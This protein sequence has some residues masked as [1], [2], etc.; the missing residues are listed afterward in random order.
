MD[1]R[2]QKTRK[3]IFQAF[4]K[5]LERKNY[6]NITVQEIIDEADIGRSTF[7]AHF[8]TKDD[9]VREICEEIFSHVFSEELI[10][11]TT[12][13]FTGKREIDQR[14]THML[15]HLFLSKNYIRGLLACENGEIFMRYFKEYLAKV[16]EK[17][18]T[19]AESEIPKDYMLNHLVCDFA[20]T[21][22]WWMCHEKY[23]PEEISRFF[24]HTTPF[25]R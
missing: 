18:L 4:V 24:M 11:E 2:Q 9:L 1:R 20:E 5:L 17:Y 10:K 14:I 21:V 15:Y 16:L 7:Y 25:I 12:H 8:E 3:A 13:D 23:S 6:G 22:R 19:E